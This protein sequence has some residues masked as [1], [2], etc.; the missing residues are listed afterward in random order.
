M[1][2]WECEYMT[3]SGEFMVGSVNAWLEVVNT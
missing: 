1:H 3:G 2:D